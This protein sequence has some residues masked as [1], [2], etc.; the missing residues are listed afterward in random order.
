[1]VMSISRRIFWK[2]GS[3]TLKLEV[4]LKVTTF[5]RGLLPSFFIILG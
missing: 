1:M 2:G 3:F 4:P 5:G